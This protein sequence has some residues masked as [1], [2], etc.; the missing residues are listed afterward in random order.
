VGLG[1]RLADL[2]VSF[3][4]TAS[5]RRNACRA[6]TPLRTVT[7]AD[8]R[9]ASAAMNVPGDVRAAG[10]MSSKKL[11]CAARRPALAS[12][13]SSVSYATAASA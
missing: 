8:R 3:G 4:S 13:R 12:M 9:L 6:A 11:L 2:S 5:R 10:Q 1:D 7:A